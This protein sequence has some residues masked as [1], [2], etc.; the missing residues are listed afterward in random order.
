[1]RRLLV[2][3][4]CC[5]IP[6]GPLAAQTGPS[7][8]AVADFQKGTEALRANQPAQAVQDFE[9]VTREAPR[10]AEAYLNLGLVLSQLGRDE[11][12]VQALEKGIQIK[13]SMRGAHLF[14]AI[15]DYRLGRF[16]AA[17]TA[18]RKETEASSKDA[19]AWMW[20]G[21]IDL[22]LRRLTSAI[23]AL[24]RASTLDPG[25]VDILYHRGRAAQAL[26]RESYETMFKLD[27]HSWHVAQVL[28]EA[29]VESG[30]DADAIEQYKAAI[31]SAPPQSG[32]Y[33]ALGSA[34]WR[35]GKYPEAQQAYEQAVK[36]DPNDI[37]SVYKLGC[38]EIDR[39][40]PASG[41]ALLERVPPDDPSLT[42]TSYYLGRAETQLGNDAAAIADFKHAIQQNLD[43]ETTKQAWFQ[44]SRVYRRAHDVPASEE[45][46]ARYRMLDQKSKDVL[47]EKMRQKHLRGDRD[48]SIPAASRDAAPTE[49]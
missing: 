44:L 27:P 22:A 34:L 25:N 11:E 40:D 17:S 33:E 21:I 20:Q 31:A 16:D 14:L 7:P 9:Q 48:T 45:A 19:Q 46:Q 5:A 39:S 15:S 41:K 49:P 36:I 18:V 28:A 4:I 37:V 10:F 13:P 32:L 47:L 24:D 8:A 35:T 42:M 23:E 1:M 29:D 30:N 6:T 43:D 12:A 38:L 3:L 26:S 2:S